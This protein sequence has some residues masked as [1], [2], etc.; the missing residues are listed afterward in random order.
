MGL[1]Y[2]ESGKG[3]FASVR[4]DQMDGTKNFLKHYGNKLYLSFLAK[5]GTQQERWQA[6]KELKIAERKMAFWEKHPRYEP[7]TARQGM[8]RLNKEWRGA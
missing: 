4:I 2:D 5:N 6:E 7:L 3:D 8:E 1:V